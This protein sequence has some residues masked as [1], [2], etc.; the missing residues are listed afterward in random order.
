MNYRKLGFFVFLGLLVVCGILVLLRD[1]V[2]EKADPQAELTDLSAAYT[3]SEEISA[4][5]QRLADGVAPAE[6]VTRLQDGTK[7]LAIVIDGLPE[8]A[9]T[10]R[11]LDV[12][13]KHNAPAVFFV[14]GQNA[15]EQ[16]ETIQRIYNTGYEIGNYT[17]VGI[18]SAEKLPT[19]RLISELCRT[20]KVVATL[21]PKAP[22]LFRAP[23]TVFTDPLLMAVKA[24]GSDYAVKENVRH[25]AGT[26]RDAADAAAFAATIPPGSILAI[27]ISR[28]VD[29]P[30]KEAGKTDERPA[31]D[32]KP[33][34]EDPPAV[35]N[36]PPPSDPADELD[37]LLTALEGAGMRVVDI[38]DFRKIRYIPAIPEVEPVR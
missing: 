24:A 36:T 11:M 13:E 35:R 7:H 29:P 27:G 33:N 19:E 1:Y 3:A 5:Q 17:F 31:V 16:P 12:L 9:L 20:Q 2:I 15:A 34:I 22:T 37:W 28:P 26:F 38:H 14:E 6:V 4:A 10:E 18:S 8:R 23:R 32:K 21:S 25:E 30:S